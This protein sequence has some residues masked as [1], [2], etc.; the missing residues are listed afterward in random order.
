LESEKF[1]CVNDQTLAVNPAYALSAMT[2]GIVATWKAAGACHD[3]DWLVRKVNGIPNNTDP[4]ICPVLWP[5][6][7]AV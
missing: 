1:F 4:E 6:S 5:T 3:N 2:P 7:P